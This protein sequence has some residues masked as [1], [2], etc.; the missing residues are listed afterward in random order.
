MGLSWSGQ[1]VPS[2]EASYVG[3]LNLSIGVLKVLGNLDTRLRLLESNNLAK[4]ISSPRVV[5]L[6]KKAATISQNSTQP[7]LTGTPGENSDG[8]ATTVAFQSFNLNMSVTPQIT[9]DGGVLMDVNVTRSVPVSAGDGL[10][11]AQAASSSSASTSVLVRNG[12]TA[13]VGGI[14]GQSKAKGTVGVP[15]VS[16]L[17][18]IGWLFKS[19][20]EVQ[21]K[22]ELVVFL[23]PRVLDSLDESGLESGAGF[24]NTFEEDLEQELDL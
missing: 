4:V 1:L 23:T 14:Y 2:G 15:F 7:Y 10:Q 21:S 24:D 18:L 13:V 22:S 3:N 11:G 12:Q 19:R 20:T 16:S 9:S 8:A 5:T 17:P 6:N